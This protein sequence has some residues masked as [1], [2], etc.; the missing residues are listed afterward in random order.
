[1][2]RNRIVMPVLL[3]CGLVFSPA[4]GRGTDAITLVRDGQP[5][6]STD[7]PRLPR[8]R[9]SHIEAGSRRATTHRSPQIYR[10]YD[11]PSHGEQHDAAHTRVLRALA[12]V[13]S[14]DAQRVG[15]Q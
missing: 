6:A 12:S 14:H 5:R 15:A 11:S 10:D 13:V 2:E 8:G 4:V 7:D 9:S 3:V 1:M